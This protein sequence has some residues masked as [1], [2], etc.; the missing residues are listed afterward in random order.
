MLFVETVTSSKIIYFHTDNDYKYHL[1]I[2][3]ATNL[4]KYAN[5]FDFHN[6][7]Q[8]LFISRLATLYIGLTIK[9][10]C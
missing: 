5:L 4:G 6:S 10:G 1:D 3:T 7:I 9:S 8:F 2:S